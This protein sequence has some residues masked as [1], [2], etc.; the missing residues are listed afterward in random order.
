MK[1]KIVALFVIAAF[2]V[3]LAGLAS[4]RTLAQERDAV[5]AYLKVLDAKIIKYRSAGNASK[6]KQLQK[7]K[8]A[9]LRRWAKIRAEMMKKAAPPPPP[10]PRRVAPTPKPVVKKAAPATKGLFGWDVNTGYSVGYLAGKAGI[11]GRADVILVDGMGLGPMVGLS[12]DA[13]A[14]KIGLGAVSG[15]DANDNTRTAIP[16]YV[17]GILNLP[18][19]VMGG[20]KSYIGAGLNYSV[21]GSSRVSGS[22]GGQVYYGIKGDVGLGGDSYAEIGY[23]IVRSGT[24]VTRSYSFKGITVNFGTEL[25]L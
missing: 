18:A 1:K 15:K 10:P 12:K 8:A 20:V 25:L 24:G 4:G 5:R 2:V 6:V 21:Y 19:D 7:I 16:I 14:W 3:T 9:T 23:G 22:Y 13:V 11:T 17:D